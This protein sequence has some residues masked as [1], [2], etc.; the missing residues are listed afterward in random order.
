M[1]GNTI[2]IHD[3]QMRLASAVAIAADPGRA[4]FG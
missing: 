1:I 2:H 4:Q 3:V